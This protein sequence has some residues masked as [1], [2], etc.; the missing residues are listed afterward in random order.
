MNRAVFIIRKV[1]ALH[2][3]FGL[4]A[5][6]EMVIESRGIFINEIYRKFAKVPKV[7]MKAADLIALSRKLRQS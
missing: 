4:R 1:S 6:C 5:K 3:K 2:S 7:Q